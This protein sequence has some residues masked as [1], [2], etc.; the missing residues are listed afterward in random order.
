M[1]RY[2]LSWAW[3]ARVYSASLCGRRSRVRVRWLVP[4]PWRAA[5]LC[6]P[7]RLLPPL[8]VYCSLRRVAVP[9]LA[10]FLLF[11]AFFILST[12]HRRATGSGWV[13]YRSPAAAALSCVC[14]VLLVAAVASGHAVFLSFLVLSDQMGPVGLD[15]NRSGHHLPAVGATISRAPTPRGRQTDAARQRALSPFRSCTITRSGMHFEAVFG[16][17]KATARPPSS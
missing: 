12:T 6:V 15:P 13:S 10:L 16:E 3:S 11:S 9:C 2:T 8:V 7:V 4:S 5:T 14:P 1:T 17:L